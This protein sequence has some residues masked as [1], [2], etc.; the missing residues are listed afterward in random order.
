MFPFTRKA[1]RRSC[2]WL[3]QERPVDEVTVRDIVEGCGRNRNPFYA[4]F[5]GPPSLIDATM[6]EEVDRI[7]QE[8]P[9]GVSRPDSRFFMNARNSSMFS[10]GAPA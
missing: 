9:D 3:P 6:R 8:K 4:P 10:D 2:V 1:I 7:I 5:T